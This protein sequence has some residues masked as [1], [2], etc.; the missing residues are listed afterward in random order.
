MTPLRFSM[1]TATLLA[2]AAT[3][4]GQAPPPE[5]TCPCSGLAGWLTPYLQQSMQTW[6]RVRTLATGQMCDKGVC[7]SVVAGSPGCSKLGSCVTGAAGCVKCSETVQAPS[8][9]CCAKACACCESCKAKKDAAAHVQNLGTCAQP[10]EDPSNAFWDSLDAK[11]RRALTGGLQFGAGVNC[12]NGVVGQIAVNERNFDTSAVQQ[13]DHILKIAEFYA[14]TGHPGAAQFYHELMMR[15]NGPMPP[16]IPMP[17]PYQA[18]QVQTMPMPPMWHGGFQQPPP[19][20]MSPMAIH[21]PTP[22]MRPMTLQEAIALALENG[23]VS[24]NT[25]SFVYPMPVP[26][27]MAHQVVQVH[28]IAAQPM[29]APPPPPVV[30]VAE[31]VADAPAVKHAHL[32]TPDLEAHCIRMTHRGDTIILEGDVILLNKKHAQPIRIEAQRAV[33]NMKDGTITVDGPGSMSGFGVCD[34]ARLTLDRPVSQFGELNGRKVIAVELRASAAPVERAVAKVDRAPSERPQKIVLPLKNIDATQA[35]LTLQRHL[36]GADRMLRVD[37]NVKLHDIRIAI[38]EHSNSI[39][40]EAT[41]EDFVSALKILIDLDRAPHAP[42]RP[43][44]V[45]VPGR[46]Q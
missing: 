7:G 14:R 17:V 9:C 32:V 15:R 23:T 18:V 36:L 33:I 4:H 29:C 30:H 3:V 12:D 5:P 40:V 45:V 10:C 13:A 39:I 22:Q 42:V 41:S 1:L 44:T 31:C 34:Q 37:D 43:T 35:A 11:L 2:L 24:C 28:A 6:Q 27:P 8:S 25:P 19:C 26:P 16:P 46:K 38:D 20:C 21:P